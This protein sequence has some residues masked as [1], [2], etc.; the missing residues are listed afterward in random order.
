MYYYLRNFKNNKFLYFDD[1][2][3]EEVDR[4]S[5]AE[6]IESRRAAEQYRTKFKER[7]PMLEIVNESGALA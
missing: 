5:F 4:T 2:F 1:E 6:K 3:C 7:F